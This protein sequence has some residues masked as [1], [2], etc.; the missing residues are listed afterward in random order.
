[1]DPVPKTVSFHPS[2]L[3]NWIPSS[4]PLVREPKT[5]QSQLGSEVFST[6]NIWSQLELVTVNYSETAFIA[7]SSSVLRNYRLSNWYCCWSVD[8]SVNTTN[9]GIW[10]DD[11][12]LPIL[13]CLFVSTLSLGNVK[14]YEQNLNEKLINK[15]NETDHV[16]AV[17]TDGVLC[18][19]KK[20]SPSNAIQ[21][22]DSRSGSFFVYVYINDVQWWPSHL[23]RSLKIF[24]LR[25]NCFA[26]RAVRQRQSVHRSAQSLSNSRELSLDCEGFLH[27]VD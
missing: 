19:R 5:L 22:R 6:F 1:M 13:Y 21:A 17:V 15:I 8:V 23:R 24:R 26:L 9:P 4:F 27:L 2:L 12:N 16:M 18:V 3:G 25:G 10:N 11:K 20:V 7:F 14:M